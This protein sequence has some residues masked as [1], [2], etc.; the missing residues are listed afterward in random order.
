MSQSSRCGV[1]PRRSCS[2]FGSRAMPVPGE[3]FH[4]A[5][6]WVAPGQAVDYVGQIR[7]GIEAI[8]LGALQH[9]VEGSG[10]L[11]ASL[12]AEKQEILAGDGNGT[13]RPLGDIVV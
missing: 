2:Q 7:L 12:G 9:R 11:A 4:E 6:D 8:E 1:G 5:V 10:P 13:Q 3:Q